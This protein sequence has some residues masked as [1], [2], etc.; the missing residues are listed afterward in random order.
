MKL[1]KLLNRPRSLWL[2]IPIWIVAAW[3][4]LVVGRFLIDMVRPYDPKPVDEVA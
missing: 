1:R 4:L 3:L 2:R